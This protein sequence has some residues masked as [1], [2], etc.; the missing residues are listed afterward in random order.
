MYLIVL[1]SL[2][3][4]KNEYKFFGCQCKMQKSKIKVNYYFIK[5]GT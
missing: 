4:V 5:L 1:Q 3:K 2:T